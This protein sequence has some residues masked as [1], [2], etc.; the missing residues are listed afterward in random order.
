MNDNVSTRRALA[1]SA[2][3]LGVLTFLSR[4]LGFT[5]DVLMAGLFGTSAAAEAFVVSFKLPNLFRD[6]VGEGAMNAAIVPVLSDVRT[7]DGEDAF[8]RLVSAL[9]VW[10]IVILG[11]L[12]AAGVWFAPA[13]VHFA[14]PGFS[15]DPAKFELTVQL[16]RILFPFIGLVGFSALLMGVLNTLRVFGS[17]AI[18]SSLLNLCMIASIFLLT[19]IWGVSG[20]AYG[21]L[22][23]GLV[24]LAVQ[25]LSFGRLGIG[26]KRGPLV[27]P[28]VRKIVSLMG[29]RL[30][31][32]AVYQTSVFIDTIIASFYWIVGDG[33]QSALYYSSRLFQLP[34]ALFGVSFAQA[35][36]PTLSAHHAKGET[37]QFRDSA[38][39]AMRHVVFTTMPAAIGLAVFS[40]PII[41]ILFKRGAFDDYSVWVTES[42]LFY[43]SFGLVACG[44]LKVLANAFYAMH[45]TRTPVKAA[46]IG[47]GLNLVLNVALMWHLKIG[48]LALA[49]SISTTVNAWLLYL[50][51]TKKLGTLDDGRLAETALKAVIAGLA[52][53][54][55]GAFAFRP[56]IESAIDAGEM[57]Q[58]GVRL[59]IGIFAC[60]AF[61]G[62]ASLGLLSGEAQGI[63]RAVSRKFSPKK[64]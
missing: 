10:F 62:A 37:A 16:T 6:V 51:L 53:G 8:R 20:M 63:A 31:G 47:L 50:W 48:G 46:T 11:I 14:A 22:I 43:Y 9:C 49:T 39:F 23:G 64:D 52:M 33:G 7:K 5:R 61:Y 60:L 12:C 18:G 27:V 36:L 42:A 1:R 34:L 17:S 55:F 15:Q 59:A 2:G 38:I 4:V 45:D 44:L 29:P 56:W 35:S 13:V 58:G 28:G 54:L 32:T 3:L 41:A 40:H 30:W 24:Q 25:M 19:P 57:L 26:W 21:V